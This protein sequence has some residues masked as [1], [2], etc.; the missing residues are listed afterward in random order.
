V[1]DP[2]RPA[3]CLLDGLVGAIQVLGALYPTYLDRLVDAYLGAT[4]KTA[5]EALLVD[6]DE[7]IRTAVG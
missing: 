5:A 1:L 3:R 4:D 6:G 2:S 7:V